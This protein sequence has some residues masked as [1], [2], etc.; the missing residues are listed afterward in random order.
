MTSINRTFLTITCA[1]ATMT[2]IL[3]VSSG[4]A[5]AAQKANRQPDQGGEV[6][7]RKSTPDPGGTWHFKP[8]QRLYNST[9]GRFTPPPTVYVPNQRYNAT[10]G[11]THSQFENSR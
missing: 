11:I 6:V 8:P 1:A 2:A 3:L 7:I 10:R 5:L 9:K 4:D